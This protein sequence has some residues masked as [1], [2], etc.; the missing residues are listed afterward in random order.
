VELPG[1]GVLV[2]NQVL[3]RR[4]L[5]IALPDS[6][7]RPFSDSAE[8]ATPPATLVGDHLVAFLSG[9]VG[10]PAM[11]T[12]AT[13]GESR[14]IR[15][16]EATRGIAP[17]SLAAS[18]D[19]KTLYYVNAGS[20]YSV[21]VEGGATPQKLRSAIGV[22]VDAHGPVPT[23]VVQ[24]MEP[25]GVKLYQVRSGGEQ[26]PILFASPLRLDASPISGGAVGFDGQIAVTVTSTDSSFRSVAL[27]D[28]VTAR[29][30]RVPVLFDGDLHHPALGRDGSLL[31]MGVS[32]RSS[33]WRFQAQDAS[34]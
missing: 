4:R 24:A 28:P 25:D 23:L 20:L 32:V 34:R 27:L 12:V 3:G 6:Q 15:R 13:I 8:Q 2:P 10:A 5:W 33:L 17:Q 29:L 14:V 11:L 7:L 1:G 31:A 30:E 21:G 9:R 16:L 22:T 19:G 18:P 26:L